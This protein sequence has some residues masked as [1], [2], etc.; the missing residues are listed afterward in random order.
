[1]LFAAVSKTSTL[2]VQV[3]GDIQPSSSSHVDSENW[4]RTDASLSVL[5]A[6]QRQN[7]LDE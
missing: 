3:E 5:S 7:S 1:M 2:Q 6:P 4:S